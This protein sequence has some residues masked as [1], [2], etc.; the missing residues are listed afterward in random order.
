MWMVVVGL[1][2]ANIFEGRENVTSRRGEGKNQLGWKV[3]QK[4]NISTVNRVRGQLQKG[5]GGKVEVW[6]AIWLWLGI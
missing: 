1:V 4:N 2:L 6:W 3:V 5:S